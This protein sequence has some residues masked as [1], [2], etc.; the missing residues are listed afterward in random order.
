MLKCVNGR[1]FKVGADIGHYHADIIGH[2]VAVDPG[3]IHPFLQY[4]VVD[5]K[6]CDTFHFKNL[7]RPPVRQMNY[8]K[9]SSSVTQTAV[10]VNVLPR[11]NNGA[12]A[13]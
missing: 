7:P 11:C 9:L 4:I 5:A 6:T 13:L 12:G 8:W 2:D 3:G 10:A 1:I